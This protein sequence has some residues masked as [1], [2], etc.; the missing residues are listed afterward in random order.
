MINAEQVN[1]LGV[2]EIKNNISLYLDKFIKSGVI[3]FRNA[4]LNK[5]EHIIFNEHLSSLFG[6]N[7]HK[8]TESNNTYSYTENHS[9]NKGLDG[10]SSDDIA[11]VWHIEHVSYQN[12]IVSG[13]W[14]MEVFNTDSENGKTYFVDSEKIYNRMSDD[15]KNF[16]SS[17]LVKSKINEKIYTPVQEHWITKNPVLR[18]DVD[19]LKFNINYTELYSVN[20]NVPTQNDLI[21]F[22]EIL[23]WFSNEVFNNENIRVVH[24]WQQGDLVLVDT[25][26]MAHA[27]TGGF[28]PSDR[29]FTG[30]WGFKD[31]VSTL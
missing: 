12:P 17:C 15:W 16:L 5:E 29:E 1:F 27:V 4:N 11:L 20:H 8:N 6:W 22:N 14:N 23:Q 10:S 28:K 30:I 25:F 26:K 18:L 24:K 7:I 19:N 3:V 31:K 21:V 2:N 13:T 9:Q